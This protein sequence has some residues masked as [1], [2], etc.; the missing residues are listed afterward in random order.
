ML[1]KSILCFLSLVLP[2]CLQ[3]VGQEQTLSLIKPD[4]VETNH[5]GDI[6]AKFEKENIRIAGLKMVKLTKKQAE[7]FY[8]V[9]RGKPFYDTL[10]DYISSG[11]LVAI[12][13]EGEGAVSKNRSLMGATDPSKAAP[14][15]IRASY[16]TSMTRNAVHGSD[17]V[18]NAKKEIS[19][20]FTE[21]EIYERW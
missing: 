17:S 6:I 14:N 3:A 4:T 1:K 15:T 19:F 20:F 12:V 16:A 7:D 18:E 13:L 5:I 8:D 11:P 21:K 2:Y 10:T 9:H